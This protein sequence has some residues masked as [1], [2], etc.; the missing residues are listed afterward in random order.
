M[1]LKHETLFLI[2]LVYNKGRILA[3]VN[4]CSTATIWKVSKKIKHFNVSSMY[5]I[6]LKHLWKEIKCSESKYYVIFTNIY[7][8]LLWKKTKKKNIELDSVHNVYIFFWHTG[9]R[10]MSYKVYFFQI[11][12][13]VLQNYQDRFANVFS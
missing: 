8:T 11:E 10:K 12:S 5:R 2:Q 3:T 4:T 9:E 13:S 1:C 7:W 6:F